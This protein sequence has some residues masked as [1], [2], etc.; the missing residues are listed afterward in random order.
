M[1]FCGYT[2]YIS[3]YKNITDHKTD[4]IFHFDLW[5]CGFELAF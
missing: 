1:W 3:D 4:H 5:F 2:V